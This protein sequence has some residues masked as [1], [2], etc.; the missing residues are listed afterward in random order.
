MRRIILIFLFISIS[1]AC[2]LHAQT[3]ADSSKNKKETVKKGWTLGLL[4]VV[5]Y[6]ADL[7]LQYGGIVNLFNYGKGVVYPDYKH[8]IKIEV[9]RYTRGTGVN[10]L[11]YDSKY[12]LPRHIR[13]TADLSYLTE[14]TLDFYGF[15]GYEASYKP[16]FVDKNAADYISRVYYRYERKMLRCLADF[17]GK[18]Y[19]NHLLW[20]AGVNFYDIVIGSVDTAKLN[21]GK[22]G[23]KRLPNVDGL[24]D[25]YVKWGIISNEEKDGCA[26]S[27]LKLGL[28]YDTRDNESNAMH[29][30]W[31][32]VIVATAPSLFGLNKLPYT[33]LVLT[34]R[35]YFTLIKNRLS[36]VYRLSYQGTI[37][38]KTPFF[39]QPYMIS[40]YSAATKSDGLGGAKNLRGIL[41]NRVV[42][43]DVTYG[44][45]E[46]RWKIFK[47]VIAKQNFY[48]G[49]NTFSDAGMVLKDVY[50][51]K[52]FVPATEN[53]D[54]YFDEEKD[55]PHFSYGAGLRLALN[56]NFIVAIDYGL[57]VYEKDG[58]GGLYINISNLF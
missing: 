37:A 57:A 58:T 9:S 43:D 54:N 11:F 46:V 4:P 3:N 10:Q 50:I 18:L 1:A 56:E 41:R 13:I 48:L 42:G 12:L 40:S 8:S 15:N 31:S 30:I 38:G 49:F 17:Q 29:G 21:K 34:H 7:G 27:M 19:G 53:P 36:F 33:K 32:E 26:I 35:Q 20:L 44:N 39:M 14:K 47:T 2:Y 5:A 45:F 22:E 24:Y 51:D 55:H 6:D 23:D 16:D 52:S 28:I 25:K